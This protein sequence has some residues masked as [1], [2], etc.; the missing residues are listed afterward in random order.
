MGAGQGGGEQLL[1][2]GKSILIFKH[3][4]LE[5]IEPAL[6]LHQTLRNLTACPMLLV[7]AGKS[8]ETVGAVRKLAPGLYHGII[9]RFAPYDH[10][11]DLSLDL[12]TQLCATTAA[13]VDQDAA[14]AVTE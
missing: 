10:A 9:D 14:A 4:P 11:D 3:N 13:M 2:E 8:G 5:A 6:E 1:E 7:T 12:W